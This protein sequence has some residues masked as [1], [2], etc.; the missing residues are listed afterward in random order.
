MPKATVEQL[1]W[2]LE[3]RDL[4][5][6]RRR[7]HRLVLLISRSVISLEISKVLDSRHVC[8]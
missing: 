4:A 5:V 6:T 8:K 3:G 2:L 7:C 1:H